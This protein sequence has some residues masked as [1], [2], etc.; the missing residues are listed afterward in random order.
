V[1]IRCATW[2]VPRSQASKGST[3]TR[4]KQQQNRTTTNKTW[5][6]PRSQASKGS[7]NTRQKQQQNNNKQ[8]LGVPEIPVIKRLGLLARV[9]TKILT[10]Q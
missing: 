6:V 1:Y 4:Q 2:E 3:N 7:T 5:E 9:L 8:D 10:S